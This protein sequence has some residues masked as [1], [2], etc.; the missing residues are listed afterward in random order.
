MSSSSS[1]LARTGCGAYSAPSSHPA[2]ERARSSHELARSSS[3]T[4]PLPSN[5]SVTASQSSW[6]PFSHQSRD[7]NS[8][9]I[10]SFFIELSSSRHVEQRAVALGAA[11]GVAGDAQ[12]L[13]VR[14]GLALGHRPPAARVEQPLR[15]C[16]HRR[17]HAD[18]ARDLAHAREALDVMALDR[19]CARS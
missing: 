19:A 7:E 2:M 1:A 11:L 16:L 12:V 17:R 6:P 3:T 4:T 13:E 9:S 18:L 15:E 5:P 10:D 8:K 14:V